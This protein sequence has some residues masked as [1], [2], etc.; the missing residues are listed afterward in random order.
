MNIFDFFKFIKCPD[1]GSVDLYDNA[2]VYEIQCC[3]CS[4]VGNYSEDKKLL[5]LMPSKPKDVKLCVKRLS[6]YEYYSSQFYKKLENIG[7]KAN[8]GWSVSGPGASNRVRF[9]HD[10]LSE[11]VQEK[12]IKIN[13]LDNKTMVDLSA[14]S[15]DY[16]FQNINNFD[17]IFHCEIDYDGLI[18]SKKRADEMGIDNIIFV[19]CDYLQIPFKSK[20]FNAILLIDSLEYYGYEN[21]HNVINQ[22]YDILKEGGLSILDFHRKRFFKDNNLLYEYDNKDIRLVCKSNS[23]IKV[24]EF[25]K[26]IVGRISG[27]SYNKYIYWILNRM[28][29]LPPVRSLVVMRR[30]P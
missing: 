1:C 30:V 20:S 7:S 24:E 21:D 25:S 26:A 17:Y 5:D 3:E 4:W 18:N 10:R 2:R 14:G 23:G 28:F 8:S 16:T 13:Q 22:S 6:V 19:H 12:L 29:F 27:M 9:F 15:G 11:V